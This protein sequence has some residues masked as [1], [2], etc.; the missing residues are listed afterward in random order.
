MR[1]QPVTPTDRK[2][3]EQLLEV[4]MRA[5]VCEIEQLVAKHEKHGE[6]LQKGYLHRAG[7]MLRDGIEW[8]DWARRQTQSR[9]EGGR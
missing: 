9:S 5:M 7:R 6:T 8:F 4:R 2:E 1:S 3:F